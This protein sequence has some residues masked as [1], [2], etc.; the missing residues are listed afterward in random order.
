MVPLPGIP[1]NT[2]PAPRLSVPKNWDRTPAFSIPGL[3]DRLVPQELKAYW[4]QQYK[5][6]YAFTQDL[7]PHKKY[8]DI[9]PFYEFF[10]MLPLHHIQRLLTQ[11]EL[12][13]F[14][15]TLTKFRTLEERLELQNLPF[16]QVVNK[17]NLSAWHHY[18]QNHLGWNATTQVIKGLR[19]LNFSAFDLSTEL[20]FTTGGNKVGLSQF[21]RTFLDGEIAILLRYKGQHVLT[22]SFNVCKNQTKTEIVI[23]Q[24]QLKNPKGN[25]FLF[26]LGPNYS[27]TL[28]KTFAE[29]FSHC[30][31]YLTTGEY[32]SK[33]LLSNYQDSRTG[34]S[35]AETLQLEQ[36]IQDFQNIITPRLISFYNQPFRSL[37]KESFTPARHKLCL[38]H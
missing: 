36:K 38:T 14:E 35:K 24:I 12:T 23:A 13:A 6:A 19:R 5:K 37:K 2:L 9:S 21:S 1:L 27:E 32:L 17:S 31:V 11:E 7:S 10:Q 16:Y 33:T 15:V 29:A 22:L 34:L 18:A 20:D 25:R 3:W 26:K 30:N 4:P 28:C 8:T